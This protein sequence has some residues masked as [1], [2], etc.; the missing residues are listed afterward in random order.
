MTL[1]TSRNLTILGICTIVG[2]LA[3]AAFALFDG[4]P[5][6]N[7]NWEV[8]IAAVVGGISSI[9][10]KGSSSTGGTVDGAGKPVESPT[11]PAAGFV[12]PGLLLA[13]LGVL[14]LVLSA[15]PRLVRADETPRFGG[16][17]KDG[18]TCFGPAVSLSLV[19]L[20]LKTGKVTT[21]VAPGVGYGIQWFSASWYKTEVSI[22]ASFRDTAD[23]QRLVPSAVLG[24][25]EYGRLG[26]GYQIGSKDRPFLLLGIGANFGSASSGG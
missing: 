10:A 14:V 2:A 25:A 13:L 6:T 9:L 7:P 16:C 3:T 8:T 19:Q 26:I 15:A 17:L 4:D 18:T 23:G 22:F 11:P 1:A 20:D 12:R 5:A 24:F 21:G